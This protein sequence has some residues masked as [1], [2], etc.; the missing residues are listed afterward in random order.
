MGEKETIIKTA[1]EILNDMNL[2]FT[3]SE[4][5]E[6]FEKSLKEKNISLHKN[7]YS[8]ILNSLEQNDYI[9]REIDY[10]CKSHKQLTSGKNRQTKFVYDLIAE[11][12]NQFD[13]DYIK[14]EFFKYCINENKNQTLTPVIEKETQYAFEIIK[15][16]LIQNKIIEKRF[17]IANKNL[18]LD[19]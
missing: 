13:L 7:T 8:S 15:E 3:A 5:N 1:I 9:D 19:Y 16:H 4:F 11:Q 17:N 10:C 14:D 6:A 2:V 12:D 18:D